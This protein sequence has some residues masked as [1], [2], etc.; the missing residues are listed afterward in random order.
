MRVNALYSTLGVTPDA[1]DVVII[2]AYRALAQRYHPDRWS[3]DP[4]EATRRMQEINAAYR[5]LRDRNMRA[6]YDARQ[7]RE[8][9]YS[10]PSSPPP[11]S[12]ES[13]AARSHAPINESSNRAT[14]A[15]SARD[16]PLP[17]IS[18]PLIALVSIAVGLV[19]TLSLTP[20]HTNTTPTPTQVQPAS[21]SSELDAPAKA[22]E[23]SPQ[24]IAQR[25]FPSVV[26]LVGLDE[27]QQPLQ[28][29]SGFSIAPG[30]VVSNLHVVSGATRVVANV[31][32][33]SSKSEVLGYLAVDAERDLIVL[34]APDLQAPALP[35]AP[36]A[37]VQIGA[38][39]YAIGNP[40][41][42]EGTFSE[43]IV[44]GKRN[45]PSGVLLQIT[46]PISP[47]SSGGPL[48]NTRGEVLGVATATLR[49][50]QNLNFATP[51]S[52]EMGLARNTDTVLGLSTLRSLASANRPTDKPVVASVVV[53]SLL[54]DT[55]YDEDFISNS[56][57]FSVSIRNTLP[58]PIQ[59]ISLLVVFLD[60][61]RKPI[62]ATVLR[63][64]GLV[65]AG[66]ARRASGTVSPSV[67]TLTTRSQYD[68]LQ[69]ERSPRAGR[70][71][72]R[73]LDFSYADG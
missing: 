48:L 63:F 26:L 45:V 15:S 4:A 47:G 21:P 3:G 70:V 67:K 61:K 13:N 38:K 56:G 43:G 19:A 51:V 44:S 34:S 2:A 68:G 54:W 50:G 5:V 64:N 27:N 8:S 39:V 14:S 23:L 52:N 10:P 41:G 53:D 11:E 24:E 40:S 46:A 16:R 22:V 73:V 31:V 1:E 42:L 49:D 72:F 66:L 9:D 58:R 59:S 12:Q 71:E 69:F 6:A 35:L 57:G 28:L 65:P 29:G 30:V 36:R 7:A 33:D 37:D 25:S 55:P 20:R 62:D 18:V 17:T 32:G 60:Q